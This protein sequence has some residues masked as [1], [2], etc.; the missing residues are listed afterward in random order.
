MQNRPKAHSISAES[1]QLSF[2]A[3]EQINNFSQE[4]VAFGESLALEVQAKV[5]KESYISIAREVFTERAQ[6]KGSTNFSKS[7]MDQIGPE[8]YLRA[9]KRLAIYEPGPN[10]TRLPLSEE[11]DKYLENKFKTTFSNYF[12]ERNLVKDTESKQDDE[13]NI[14]KKTEAIIAV[15]LW[16]PRNVQDISKLEKLKDYLDKLGFHNKSERILLEE[17]L[18]QIFLKASID[19]EKAE[20]KQELKDIEHRDII[21]NEIKNQVRKSEDINLESFKQTIKE[22]DL[23]AIEIIKSENSKLL[24]EPVKVSVDPDTPVYANLVIDISREKLPT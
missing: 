21:K 18:M 1:A 20:Q 22:V 11:K 13:K 6:L 15:D 4:A 19:K 14:N 3:I 2:E 7:D 23:I 9:K 5:D 16:T 24:K 10:N 12:V 8:I 17:Q